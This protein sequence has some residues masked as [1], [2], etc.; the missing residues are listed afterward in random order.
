MSCGGGNACVAAVTGCACS[1][2]AR[3]SRVIV[4]GWLI[5]ERWPDLTSLG[6]DGANACRAAGDEECRFLAH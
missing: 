5:G 6:V 4:S 2:A 1:V 3:I